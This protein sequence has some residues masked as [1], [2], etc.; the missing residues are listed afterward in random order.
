MVPTFHN[1]LIVIY[2]RQSSAVLQIK[3][4]EIKPV[5]LALRKW[6]PGITNIA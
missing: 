4:Y 5:L 1:I 3:N 2:F 6:S